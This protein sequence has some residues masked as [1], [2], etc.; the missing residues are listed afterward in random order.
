MTCF[1][2]WM[3]VQGSGGAKKITIC[4][5]SFLLFHAC[6]KK[7][8]LV[9]SSFIRYCIVCP[10][11]L[12]VYG[13]PLAGRPVWGR[14]NVDGAVESIGDWC[15]GDWVLSI[16]NMSTLMRCLVPADPEGVLPDN[17]EVLGLSAPCSVAIIMCLHVRFKLISFVGP[18]YSQ[19]SWIKW[20]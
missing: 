14:I 8:N 7:T 5:I 18:K 16:S 9:T 1:V 11:A 3:F 17:K 2:W 10:T 19:L 13:L 20:N 12:P 15:W 4:F 6:L